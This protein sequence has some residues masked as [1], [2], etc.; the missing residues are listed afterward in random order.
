MGEE[1]YRLLVSTLDNLP[2]L[3]EKLISKKNEASSLRKKVNSQRK[4]VVRLREA[5]ERRDLDLKEIGS[6]IEN[7]EKDISGIDKKVDDLELKIDNT[8]EANKLKLIDLARKR[9]DEVSKIKGRRGFSS[10]LLLAL[11]LASFFPLGIANNYDNETYED[12]LEEGFYC[13]NGERIHGSLVLNDVWD[14]PN[15]HDEDDPWF[16]ISEA[17]EYESDRDW[18]WIPWA[19]I[20]ALLCT[21]GFFVIYGA[22]V[23]GTLQENHDS[24]INQF[25]NQERELDLRLERLE[26]QKKGLK[27]RRKGMRGQIKNLKRKKKNISGLDRELDICT[28]TLADLEHDV[29]TCAKDVKSLKKQIED[30]QNAISHLIPYS[31]LLNSD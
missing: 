11:I 18:A 5:L 13:K 24:A 21:I 1:D 2:K 7:I 15:G 12:F 14:C 22:M 25:F 29:S 26:N 19:T 3:G 31:Y 27:G 4:E 16:S 17:Q 6:E 20:I 28:K 30:E 23:F 8:K 9:D 10:F